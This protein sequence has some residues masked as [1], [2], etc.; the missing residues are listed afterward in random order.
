MTNH[1]PTT[2]IDWQSIANNITTAIMTVGHGMYLYSSTSKI[3]QSEYVAVNEMSQDLRDKIA[4][5]PIRGVLV[6]FKDMIA[7]DT[8]FTRMCTAFIQPPNGGIN[9]GDIIKD[10]TEEYVVSM[11]KKQE[12]GGTILVYELEL[13]Q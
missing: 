9:L 3:G 12:V 7:E 1:V 8:N 2:A 10:G 11:V 6:D 4:P 5:A 13:K